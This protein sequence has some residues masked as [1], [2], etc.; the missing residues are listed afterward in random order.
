LDARTQTALSWSN[1]KAF[2]GY[3]FGADTVREA[4]VIPEE[5]RAKNITDYGRSHGLA[6]YFLGGYA[7]EWPEHQ[8]ARIIK[9]DSDA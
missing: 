3:I 6:W 8:Y 5:L 7:I 1:S 9:W 2:P 4:I